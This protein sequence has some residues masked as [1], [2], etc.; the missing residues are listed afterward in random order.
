MK[1]E[2]IRQAKVRKQI[3]TCFLCTPGKFI[4]L[5]L[6]DRVLKKDFKEQKEEAYQ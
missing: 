2:E 1:I 4:K 5:V 6:K 3:C